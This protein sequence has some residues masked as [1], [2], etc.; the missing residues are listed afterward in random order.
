MRKYLFL[1]LALLVPVNAHA[2]KF[3]ASPS[4]GKQIG[5]IRGL[6]AESRATVR[7]LVTFRDPRWSLLTIAQIAAST[8]DAETSLHDFHLCPTCLETGMAR[9]VVGHHP[10]AHKYAIAGVVEIG[11][12]A[13]AA[14]YLRNHG[15]VRKW[16]W[17]YVWTLPQ[18]FS[19]Y[20]HTRADF[21]N[22]GLQLRCDPS[23]LNCF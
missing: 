22:I 2:Q 11:V 7:E 16:Y 14:H 10:D 15:P 21:H 13:L 20:E 18:S 12:D 5:V 3:A 17:R 8:A 19:L 9:F 23:G 6:A 1:V 4:A